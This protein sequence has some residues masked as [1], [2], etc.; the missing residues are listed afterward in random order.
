MRRT[1]IDRRAFLGFTVAG[2]STMFAPRIAF[3]AAETE[4]RFVFVIQR[5]AA[6][7]LDIL[8]PIGDPDYESNRKHIA[9][10]PSATQTLDG[11]FAL[12]PMLPQLA[13]LYRAG[14]ATFIPAIASPYRERSHF[15]GQN[16][17][18]SG[19]NAPYRV[20]DGWMNRLAGLLPKTKTP[21]TAF[22]PGVPMAL[23]GAARVTSYA[24]SRLPNA[25]DDLMARVSALYES[26][27][28]L[29]P[30]WAAAMDAR[31]MA[32]GNAPDRSPAAMGRLAGR[33][34][35]R[36]DGPRIAMIETTGWDT[37]NQQTP[38][39]NQLL[40]GFDA[41]IASL[42]ESL[43]PIWGQTI[44]LVATEFGRTVAVNGTRGTDHGTAALAMLLGGA[45]SGGRILA[46]WPG[47]APQ[48]LFEGRDLRPTTDLD[49]LIAGCAAECFA[50]APARA[51]AVLFPEGLKMRPMEGLVR[52]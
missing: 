20:R 17:V 50:I 11:F 21:P 23:R 15:D 2:A 7:G 37:H 24:P 42:R 47:I 4:R 44:V 33:F 29:H 38:R 8:A 46:D 18:E 39:M 45:V 16:V 3:A 31:G 12:H 40:R 34:L 52:T 32:A 22:A 1:S 36:P 10:D 28:E 30:I 19:G 13:A 27:A 25:E 35:A 26:D 43:G 49:A 41:M 6:D 48:A 9:L 5:G 14:E 51:A